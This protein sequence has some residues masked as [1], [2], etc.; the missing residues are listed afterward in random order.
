MTLLKLAKF[1]REQATCISQK[2]RAVYIHNFANSVVKFSRSHA[3]LNSE[4]VH[5]LVCAY[6]TNLKGAYLEFSYAFHYNSE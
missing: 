6:T 3:K 1:E 2:R 5:H 4:I